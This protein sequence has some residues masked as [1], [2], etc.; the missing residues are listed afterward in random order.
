MFGRDNDAHRIA[1][2]QKTLKALPPGLRLLDA[3]AGQLRNQQFC[4][5]LDYVSQDFCQYEGKGDGVALQ[6][7]AWDTTRI[8]LVSDITAIPAPDQSFD[9]VLCTE[10]LEHVPDPLAAL[11]EFARLLRP[12]GRMILTAPFCSLTHFAPYHFAS[13]LSRYWYERHL[14]ELGCTVEQIQPNGGWLDYVAQELWRL[15]WIGKTYASRALGWAAL[16]LALPA[17][18]VMRAM[19]AMDRGSSELLTYGWQ[20]VAHKSDTARSA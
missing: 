2:V 16:A 10:V 6:T 14:A 18:G 7:G 3:G 19:K 17:L 5:H 12:G 20:V 4:T 9:V 1:W 15:P 8:D 11:R 13:G